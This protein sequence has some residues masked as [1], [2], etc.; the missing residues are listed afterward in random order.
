MGTNLNTPQS[1]LKKPF[2]GHFLGGGKGVG[3]V[4]LYWEKPCFYSFWWHFQNRAGSDLSGRGRQLPILN[5]REKQQGEPQTQTAR[6]HF[7]SNASVGAQAEDMEQR[8]P[9]VPFP[10]AACISRPTTFGSLGTCSTPAVAT[11]LSA[12]PAI[13]FLCFCQS[14][15]L[16]QMS[17]SQK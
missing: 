9:W 8:R 10:A 3:W 6:T 16:H 2:L 4:E 14:E 17:H 11:A 13:S 7:Q 12:E 15:P 5:S 1:W